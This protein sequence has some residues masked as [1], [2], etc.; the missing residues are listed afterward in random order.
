MVDPV[1]VV[2][3]AVAALLAGTV[4]AI[5]GGGGL[6]TLPALLAAGLPPHL[7]LGTNKGGSVWGSGSALVTYYRAG[8]VDMTRALVWFVLAI[9]GSFVG[10]QL[11]LLL[12]PATLRPVVIAMLIGAAVLLMVKKP[13]RDEDGPPTHPA[14]AAMLALVIGAYDGFFGPGTGTFLIVGFVAWCGMSMVRATANA[15]VVNFASNLAA[16]AAFA[17]AGTVVWRIALPMAAGQLVG[18]LIGARLA[19]KGGATLVRI[20]VLLVSGAL[21]IKVAHDL[22][23]SW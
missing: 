9:G 16:L 10:A 18:G 15:K 5:A 21:V 14:I 17:R 19:I 12:D 22:V 6:I 7:A 3:L 20:M 1:V 13:S 4:D 23:K 8:R 11:Q 2:M